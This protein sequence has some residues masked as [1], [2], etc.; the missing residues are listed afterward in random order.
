MPKIYDN[1]ENKLKEGINKTLKNAKRADFCI[2]YFN[3]RGWRQI[4]QQ[5]DNLSGDY[6][7]EEYDDDTKYHC[8]VLIGMQRQPVQ[9]LEDNF[10]T[11]ERSILDNAKAIE[12]KKKLAKEL[13]EQLII[14]TPN[15]EDE[16]ALQKLSEQ[17]KTGKVFVKLHLAHPLH[18]KLYLS[19]REDYNSPVIGFV[20]SSNLTF[21]GILNQGELNVDVVEQDA[22]NKLAEWYQNRWNNRWSIDISKELVEILDESWA[23]EREIPPYYIYLKTA[24]H[25]ASEARAGMAEFS[26]SKRFQREL[27]PY[28]ANAVKISAHH[29]HKRGGVLIGDVVGLGKTITAI[30]L[31]KIFE[32]DFFLETLIICPK[33]L[34]TMWEDYAHKYQLRAKV[35]SVTQIQSKLGDERRFRLMIVDE[36]HN[37]RNRKGKRYRALHEYIQLNDSKVILLTAT[38]YNKSYLDIGNQLRL[39]LDEE[40]NLGVCPEKFIESIGGRVQFSAQYQ[41]NA[42]TIGAFEKSNFSDDWNELMRLFLVRRTRSFI[43]NNYTKTDERGR[44]YLLFPNEQNGANETRQYFPK[45]IP[46]RVDFSFKRKDKN[47][48]YARLYSKK[49][50]KLIDRMR[51]PR[52]G[53]GQDNYIKDKP[54]EELESHEKTIIENLGRAGIQ[55]KG[56]ARTNLFKRL[57][58]SGYAFM[59]SVSRQ[60]LR[61]C[62]FLHA[63]EH[64]NPLPVGQ[65]ETAIID[66]YLFYDSTDKLK[67]GVM[68][69]EEKY[70]KNAAEF[71]QNLIQKHKKQYDWIRSVFFTKFLKDDLSNDNK[72][73][74]EIVNLNKKWEAEKDRKLSSLEK[75]CNVTHPHEKILIFTQYSD[76]A[77]YLHE[78][79]K[80]KINSFAHVTGASDNPTLLAHRFSPKSNDK[81]DKIS[82]KDEVRVLVS[83]DVLS[84]GQNL[85]DAHIVVNYDLPWAIIRLIQRAGRVDRI[86]QKSD[87]IFCYSFL[88]EDGIE[89]II[90][91]RNRLQ[92]RIKENAE[93]LGADETFFEG[94][95]INIKDLYNEKAGILDEEDDIEVD[96]ASYAYQI[97]KNAVDENPKLGKIVPDLSDVIYSSKKA[98][99]ENCKPGAIVYS[100]TARGNDV[101]TWIN[102]EKKIV[103]QAQFA[104]LKAL[105]CKPEEKPMPKMECHHV[106]V[107]AAIKHIQNIEDKIG[108]QLG[109]KNSAKYR[110]YIRL[111]GYIEKNKNS[112]FVTEEMKKAVEDIYHYNLQEYARETLNR[113]LRF[114]I[115]DNELAHLVVSL[116]D[117]GKLSLK[118]E[119]DES[120]HKEPKIICSMGIVN[121]E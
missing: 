94:D 38:P 69:T 6:L 9:I 99:G 103:T 41:I 113:Q 35:M 59:L 61:N 58:S 16:K 20:G 31:A 49:V 63:I 18:A 27:F 47:D 60:I 106:I 120:I 119:E 43:K 34:V 100:K 84:E 50:I 25:L 44:D 105:K 15:N 33:N 13:R 36:S 90:N 118:N 2:G 54:K 28:Q 10:I 102:T 23:G 37:L 1:I 5:V 71:Y 46:K 104:I 68:N 29:L 22:A 7:P 114:G 32:D 73:L 80:D 77:D 101:L 57:E 85:Q 55:L 110:T 17:I 70:Q 48:Q 45:R 109:K 107:A 121:Y 82:K 79:L 92:R 62:L 86:G 91:L 4:Y 115:S 67:I 78:N 66:D 56:F 51:F 112:L 76:T 40:Q 65:Q 21:S 83:T 95:P 52:Y 30:A 117:E 98:V 26:L 3:L 11:D 72:L 42:N 81:T 88:P 116:R 108:G 53:L 74:L 89:T 39:F 8:R 96:L 64:N 111:S 75:L 87:K 12:F 93:T 24:Y 97:W 19:V 14:G